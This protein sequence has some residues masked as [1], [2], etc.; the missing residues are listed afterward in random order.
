MTTFDHFF[1]K[2]INNIVDKLLKRPK[3][4]HLAKWL[5]ENSKIRL[6]NSNSAP[7]IS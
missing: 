1:N 4:H 3:F 5:K 7:I 2:V 6:L